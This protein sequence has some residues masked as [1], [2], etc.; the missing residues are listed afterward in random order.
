MSIERRDRRSDWRGLKF[1]V[2]VQGLR[3][4][5]IRNVE[6]GTLNLERPHASLWTARLSIAFMR[7]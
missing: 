6:P 2:H 1:N 3:S 5:T 7:E 4:E